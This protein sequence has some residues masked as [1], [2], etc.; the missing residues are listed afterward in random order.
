MSN[1]KKLFFGIITFLAVLIT[2]NAIYK[3]YFS[4]NI[5]DQSSQISD[6]DSFNYQLNKAIEKHKSLNESYYEIKKSEH[7]QSLKDKYG[8]DVY[9]EKLAVC[10]LFTNLY[11]NN[12]TKENENKYI[13]A[14]D[15]A[16]H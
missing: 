16:Y 5:L 3:K 8:E 13:K 9:Y 12:R 4:T 1:Y 10:E 15:P 2:I 6:S 7:I 14:C 11:Q